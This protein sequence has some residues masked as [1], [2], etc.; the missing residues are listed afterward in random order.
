[1]K[2]TFITFLMACAVLMGTVSC[3]KDNNDDDNNNWTSAQEKK[4]VGTWRLFDDYAAHYGTGWTDWMTLN[5]D[6][7]FTWERWGDAWG[8]NTEQS[9][10]TW[11]YN[12]N[13]LELR[14]KGNSEW[15]GDFDRVDIVAELTDTKLTLLYELIQE[16]TTWTKQAD[17]I[18][19][20]LNGTR[21]IHTESYWH[22]GNYQSGLY[23]SRTE[24]LTFWGNEMEHHV[25]SE[26]MYYY[27]YEPDSEPSI[28][29]E[30][31]RMPYTYFNDGKGIIGD[32]SEPNFTVSSSLLEWGDMT[33]WRDY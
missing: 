21:W 28:I 27:N 12:A 7:T 5:S 26:T 25:Y 1:M 4:L 19:T 31:H 16:V 11:S 29:D 6:H 10:G 33:F 14:R 3:N 20:E 8:E 18:S 30:S 13:T 22:Y 2:R 15:D 32:G 17:N 24:T 9:H 23:T